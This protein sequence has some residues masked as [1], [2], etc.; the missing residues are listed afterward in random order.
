MLIVQP[1]KT[2]AAY[3]AIPSSKLQLDL[4]NIK[5]KLKDDNKKIISETSFLIIT[6]YKNNRVTIFKNGKLMMYGIKNQQKAREISDYFSKKI[7]PK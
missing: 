2:S 3:E 6:K 4:R 5:K 1:C 7:Y